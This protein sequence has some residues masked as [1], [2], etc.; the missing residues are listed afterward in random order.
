MM[1]CPWARHISFCVQYWLK[2]EKCPDN[3]SN[4]SLL[5]SFKAKAWPLNV[6]VTSSINWGDGWTE[7]QAEQIFPLNFSMLVGIIK[8]KKT[9]QKQEDQDDP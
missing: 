8:K 6:F 1:L 9:P 5:I 2:L 3:N 7:V 4:Q